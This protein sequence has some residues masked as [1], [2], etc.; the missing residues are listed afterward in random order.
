MRVKWIVLF[1]AIFAFC[2]CKE[3]EGVGD[4]D[5]EG[6]EDLTEADAGEMEVEVVGCRN[7]IDCMNGLYC[8]GEEKCIDG[9]CVSGTP[10]DCNDNDPCTSDI[11]SEEEGG[12]VNDLLDEDMDGYYAE[13]APDGTTCLPEGQGDCDDNDSRTYPGASR[14]CDGK[15][16][17][18]DRHIDN[19]YDGDEYISEECSGNDCDDNDESSYPGAPRQCDDKDH[20][21]DGHIDNDY[22]GDTYISQECGGNDCND[23]NPEIH[24]GVNENCENSYDDD[25]NGVVG[26]QMV[27]VSAGGLYTCAITTG[28]GVKCWGRNDYG[29]LGDG[30]NTGRLTPVDVTGL[31]SG[32]TAISAG[33]MHT[34]ALTSGEGVKCWGWN[35]YCQLGD[36]TTTNRSTPIDVTGLSSGV[37]AISAGG[38]HTCALT[39]GGGVKCWGQNDWGQLGDGTNTS[40]NTPVDVTG[41]SSGVIAISAGGVHTC[42]LTSGGGVRCWGENFS[43]QL[44]DGTTANRLTPVDVTGLS[45]GVI[46]ISAGGSDVVEPLKH[47]CA[48]T[49]GGGVKCW[50]NNWYGQLGDGTNTNRWTPIDVYCE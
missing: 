36:G 9:R 18:C 43:G 39:S 17:D 16:H 41:L 19:D 20:D 38:A 11:C 2:A 13:K 47:T 8:D 22:D 33:G 44:G 40:S 4:A 24:P 26:S 6:N 21:C 45:S 28:G 5:G 50:G 25:C 27:M 10:P 46:A 14:Q 30:T 23:E 31:S 7:D 29:Q 37:I 34:C 15:D 48:I 42:A 32:I 12:C 49:I 3:G 35:Y 1:I